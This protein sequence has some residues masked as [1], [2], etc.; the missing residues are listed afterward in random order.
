MNY[1]T[2]VLDHGEKHKA[3]IKK[4]SH[5]NKEEI[6]EYFVFENM[7]QN[8]PDFCLLYKTSTKCHD[9]KYLNCFLCA[10]PYFRFN[11]NG[12]QT[13]NKT[14]KS[15]CSI[16]SKNSS[17]F[18]HENIQHLDCSKCTVPHTKN[19]ILKNYNENWLSIVKDSFTFS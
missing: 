4:L 19:F 13:Q 17:I 15:T 14:L 8:E 5:L 10:C 1:T 18:E 2:W 3:I 12:I 16:N 7:V 9:L 11:D 6:I